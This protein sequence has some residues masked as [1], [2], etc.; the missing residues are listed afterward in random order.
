VLSVGLGIAF[1]ALGVVIATATAYLLGT[2]WFVRRVHGEVPRAEAGGGGLPLT[3]I[4]TAALVA[5]AAALG[6]AELM[7]S[8]VP[9]GVA[10]V[11]LGL[12]A[13]LALVAYAMA[14]TGARPRSVLSDVLRV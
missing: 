3:R 4:V 5:A 8:L 9:R 7:A 1:G 11:P 10:L 14:A 2:A 12:G 6:W 13:A